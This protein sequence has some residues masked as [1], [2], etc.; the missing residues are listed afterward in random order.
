ME[1]NKLDITLIDDLI[2]A[3]MNLVS[4]EEHFWYS[5]Q[6]SKDERNLQFLNK[7][8]EMR[9]KWLSLIVTEGKKPEQRWCE[10]KHALASAMRLREVGTRFLQTNQIK[11]AK[12]AFNDVEKLI[13]MVFEINEYNKINL[14]GKTS[15]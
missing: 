15:A 7:I 8:R 10:S 4:L 13:S 12:Q 9:S 5:Y 2:E 14:N 3:L 11:E 6:I 1:K